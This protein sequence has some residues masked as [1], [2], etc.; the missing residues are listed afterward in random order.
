MYKRQFVGNGA[1]MLM[2]RA[3]GLEASDQLVSDAL[4]YFVKFYRKHSLEHTRDVYKRQEQRV[5]EIVADESGHL[6]LLEK[7]DG[8]GF[9]T[10]DYAQRKARH[11]RCV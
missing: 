5:G 10:I 9:N 1:A 4:S 3:F 7:A 6:L 8:A 2:R 11:S